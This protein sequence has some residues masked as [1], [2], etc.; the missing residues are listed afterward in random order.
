[1]KRLFSFLLFFHVCVLGAMAQ[2][3]S[4]YFDKGA[5]AYKAK[6]YGE[7]IAFFTKAIELGYSPSAYAYDYC[8]CSKYNL[9][10]YEEAIKDCSKAIELKPDYPNAYYNRG[11][12]KNVL[13]KYSE[14]IDDFNK[15][16][17]LRHTYHYAYNY[18][19]YA[20]FKLQNYAKAVEDWEAMKKVAPA[21]F[22]PFHNYID[23]A[24]KKLAEQKTVVAN[25]NNLPAPTYSKR[26]ALVVGIAQ[27]TNNNSL[28]N[29]VNDM[30]AMSKRLK[31]LGF[32]VMEVSN[33]SRGTL[34]TAINNF[35]LKLQNYEAGLVFYAGHGVQYNGKNY[36]IPSD[37]LLASEPMIEEECVSTDY[38]LAGMQGAENPV[39]FLVLDA[40]RNNPFER[41][42]KKR[43]FGDKGGLT[44]NTRSVAGTMIAFATQPDNVAQDSGSGCPIMAFSLANF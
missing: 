23:E 36:L 20:H 25:T 30:K 6:N 26:L 27:Y 14:A 28:P 13:G 42:W 5:D 38:I 37:A 43:A 17:E 1:M 10:R 15:A 3:A 29:P 24:R 7:S 39:N 18:R 40:C 44:S 32:E 11:I 4:E 19:G 12:S 8:G 21:D 22:E 34:K 41:N 9:G 35:S 31:E 16:I 33:P 2:T